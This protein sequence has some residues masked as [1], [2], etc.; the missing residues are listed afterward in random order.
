VADIIQV[1]DAETLASEPVLSA[2]Q[3]DNLHFEGDGIRLSLSRTGIEDGEPFDNTITIEREDG[4]RWI[5]V[6]KY[7]G[8]DVPEPD[9]GRFVVEI[10]LGNEAMATPRDIAEALTRLAERLKQIDG[11]PGEGVIRDING[12]TVG[13]YTFHDHN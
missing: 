8:G 5:T 10:E 13:R 3:A 4:G 1:W 9:T 11:D 2:G 12:N 7:D 6:A